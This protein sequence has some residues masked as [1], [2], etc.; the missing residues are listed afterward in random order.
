[1]FCDITELLQN[2]WSDV[3]T[4]EEQNDVCSGSLLNDKGKQSD[5][6]LSSK[7]YVIK[8]DLEGVSHANSIIYQIL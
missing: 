8:V 5:S 1:M 7:G 2:P 4:K 3:P 6:R